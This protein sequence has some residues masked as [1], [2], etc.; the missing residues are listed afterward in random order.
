MTTFLVSCPGVW[1]LRYDV[2][3]DWFVPEAVQIAF[4]AVKGT[5]GFIK[6]RHCLPL[7]VTKLQ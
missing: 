2:A 1:E 4:P 6:V 5:Y 7:Q 3:L